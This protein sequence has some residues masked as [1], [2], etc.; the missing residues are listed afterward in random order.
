[1]EV[2]ITEPFYAMSPHRT[3]VHWFPTMDEANDWA[4][5]HQGQRLGPKQV[6]P[7][8]RLLCTATHIFHIHMDEHGVPADDR[9]EWDGLDGL[10]KGH[11]LRKAQAVLGR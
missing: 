8:V 3:G 1:M 11:Y 7:D 4:A 5:K 2:T 10:A 9:P 6:D